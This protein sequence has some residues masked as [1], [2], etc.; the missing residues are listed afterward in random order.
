MAK[1]RSREAFVRTE[2]LD[3]GKGP[4][5]RMVVVSRAYLEM[6]LANWADREGAATEAAPDPKS[7]AESIMEAI[8]DE[9]EDIDAPVGAGQAGDP[10]Q[11]AQ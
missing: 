11:D 7:V 2:Y 10:T 8:L 9:C 6:I 3:D 4:A 5:T 1:K